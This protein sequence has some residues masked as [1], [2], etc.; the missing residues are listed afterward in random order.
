MLLKSYRSILF[1]I[2]LGKKAIDFPVFIIV[3]VV[4]I[5]SYYLNKAN[6]QAGFGNLFID[7]KF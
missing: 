6:G 1:Q 5:I 2:K 3:N 4:G 7:S